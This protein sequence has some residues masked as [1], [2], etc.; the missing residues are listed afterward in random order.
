MFK[1]ATSSSCSTRATSTTF[2]CYS[3]ERPRA[4]GMQVNTNIRLIVSFRGT[5]PRFYLRCH[6]LRVSIPTWPFIRNHV[7]SRQPSPARRHRQHPN[8]YLDTAARG[9]NKE[10]W[11]DFEVV[12]FVVYSVYSYVRTR[13]RST[14]QE[15]IRRHSVL[16]TVAIYH[17]TGEPGYPAFQVVAELKFD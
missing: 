12:T 13:T 6:L 9:W 17:Q 10:D 14:S 1:A 16:L 5:F 4:R 15:E 8:S 3:T 2:C 11:L 7:G